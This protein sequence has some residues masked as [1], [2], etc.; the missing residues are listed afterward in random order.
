MYITITAPSFQFI[1]SPRVLIY[2]GRIRFQILR[3]GRSALGFE[4]RSITLPALTTRFART[5]FAWELLLVLIKCC[6]KASNL[7]LLCVPCRKFNEV[8][9]LLHSQRRPYRAVGALRI[10]AQRSMSLAPLRARSERERVA[11]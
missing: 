8:N 3:L 10:Q 7:K 5:R 11:V 9:G 2:G 6:T 1:Y 4:L